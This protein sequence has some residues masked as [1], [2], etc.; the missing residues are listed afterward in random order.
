VCP[1]SWYE[2]EL[3]SRLEGSRDERSRT[4]DDCQ[5]VLDFLY[6]HPIPGVGDLMEL[7]VDAHRLSSGSL[8][9][10]RLRRRNYFTIAPDNLVKSRSLNSKIQI[11]K[12]IILENLYS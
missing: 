7:C 3:D 1:P 9:E 5:M 8:V 6:R 4:G 12:R 10:I 2:E 11:S